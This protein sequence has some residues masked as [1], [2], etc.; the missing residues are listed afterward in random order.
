MLA[1][2]GDVLATVR[3]AWPAVAAVATAKSLVLLGLAAGGAV[4]LR[5]ASAAA[6]HLVWATAM[7]GLLVLPALAVAGP[8]WPIPL[9][10]GLARAVDRMVG[11]AGT[12]GEMGL[13]GVAG[14]EAVV[15]KVGE[16]VGSEV[17]R[18]AAGGWTKP[19]TAEGPGARSEA[20][21]RG[22]RVGVVASSVERRAAAGGGG[23]DWTVDWRIGLGLVWLGGLLAGLLTLAGGLLGLKRLGRSARPACARVEAAAREAAARLGLERRVLLLEADG[24]IMPMTWGVLRPVVLLPAGAGSWPAARLEA[25]LLHELAHVQRRDPLTQLAA[26]LACA[27]HWFNPAAWLAARRLRIE[28]EHACDDAVLQAGATPSDYAGQLLDVVRSLRPASMVAVGATAMAR[29][30]QLGGRLLAV[31]DERRNRAG[32]TRARAWA[33]AACFAVVVPAIAAA[34]PQQPA[35]PPQPTRP[36]VP[37]V[38]QTPASAQIP[39][40]AQAPAL[41]QTPAVAQTPPTVRQPAAPIS[42]QEMPASTPKLSAPPAPALPP[43]PAARSWAVDPRCDGGSNHL[44]ENDNGKH[45]LIVW[46]DGADCRVV[47]EMTGDVRFTDELDGIASVPPGASIGIEVKIAGT[48][49]ELDVTAGDAGPHYDYRVDGQPRPFDADAR[50]W[51]HETLVGLARTTGLAADQRVAALLRRGGPDAVMVELGQITSDYVQR[52]YIGDLLQQAKLSSQQV[53]QVFELAGRRIHS[54]YQLA[55]TL[56]AVAKRYPL[57]EATRPAFL[58]ASRSIGSDYQHARVL[59]FAL[60]QSSLKPAD[61]SALLA[62]AQS[63]GSDYQL[64]T[65][66]TEVASRYTLQPAALSAVLRAARSVSSDYQRARVLTA[67]LA[68]DGLSADGQAAVLDEAAS[69]GSDSQLASVLTSEKLDLASAAVQQAYL[70]AAAALDSDYQHAR[71]LKSLAARKDATPQTLAL[72]LESART[73]H[74]DYQRADL[75]VTTAHAHRLDGALR[76]AYLKAADGIGSSHDRGRALDALLHSTGEGQP[77]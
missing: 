61:V 27:I 37:A 49:R 64:G 58:A 33:T 70:K 16:A 21:A 50:A 14:D 62:S 29:S 59:E 57:D 47:V 18:G 10:G 8:R 77:R 39:A 76:D 40:A 72:V 48:R 12:A 34:A 53:R 66:L 60:M 43:M 69:I 42:P 31:L 65:L 46:S 4:A 71:I 54:D 75:L 68:Q 28:R 36:Q 15:G 73:I 35:P 67:V 44:S 23:V 20:P 2:T 26:E 7:T 1:W 32:V 74:S 45:R 22:G 11:G 6:R 9:P 55:E 51:L 5:R 63:I 56:I 13:L 24:P 17:E 19:E 30:S 41:P 25:V 52:I 3:V 38:A